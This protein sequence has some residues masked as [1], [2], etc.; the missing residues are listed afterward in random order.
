MTTYILS[1]SDPILRG[2][3]TLPRGLRKL[4][5]PVKRARNTKGDCARTL[6]TT[7]VFLRKCIDKES[8]PCILFV[9][10]TDWT[11]YT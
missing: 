4:G 1:P 3:S 6:I 8:C 2:K 11:V 7:A 5:H 9:Q 10:K